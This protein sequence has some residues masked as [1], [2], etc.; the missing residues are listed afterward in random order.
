MA[1]VAGASAAASAVVVAPG[2]LEPADKHVPLDNGLLLA[3]K[4][5]SK[6]GD[7]QQPSLFSA[8]R[9]LKPQHLGL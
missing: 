5:S 4:G 2:E 7:V 8:C 6:L 9:D 1:D 3:G